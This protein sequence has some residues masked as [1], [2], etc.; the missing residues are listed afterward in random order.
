[1]QHYICTGVCGGISEKEGTCQAPDC[2]NYGN[3]LVVCSC[4]DGKHEE[5]LKKDSVETKE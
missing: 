4:E 5:V 1:M 2:G 3:D